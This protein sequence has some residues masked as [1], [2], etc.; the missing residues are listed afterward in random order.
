MGN[1][2]TVDEIGAA[3]AIGAGFS[4]AVVDV[5]LTEGADEARAADAAE[6]VD[7]IEAGAGVEARVVGA[8][9][10]VRLT[11]VAAVARR[12]DALEPVDFIDA[13]AAVE[14][15]VDGAVVHLMAAVGP[16]EAVRA[17]AHVTGVG[18]VHARG[19]MQARRVT[20]RLLGRRLAPAPV[21][22]G[23][24]HARRVRLSLIIQS[25]S[26][27]QHCHISL[28]LSLSFHFQFIFNSFSQFNSTLFGFDCQYPIRFTV[29][30]LSHL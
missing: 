18:R 20:A 21:E 27:L 14:A 22:P 24:T 30:A 25:M 2:F 6:R 4:E 17:E 23:R 5:G 10:H 16:V 11:E 13:R 29:T 28:S 8:V 9:V 12:A 7:E 3:S 1:E 26:R 19:A 15:A